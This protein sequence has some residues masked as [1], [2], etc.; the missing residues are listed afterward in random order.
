MGR[1]ARA[2]AVTVLCT[3]LAA[4]SMAGA[5]ADD[6]PSGGSDAR[7]LVFRLRITG[8]VA[9]AV[10]TTCPAPADGDVCTDTIIFGFDTRDREGNVRSD[11]PVLR[12]LTF[13]Y[14]FVED[15][16]APSEPIAEWFG[17]LEGADVEGD[18]RLDQVTAQGVVP[19]QV[20]TVF[21]P[22]SGL[23]CPD[24]VDVSATWTGVGQRQ[25]I[26]EHTV[27]RMPTRRPVRL[28][29][30]WTRGWQRDA[31]AVATL[32]GSPVP[33]VLMFAQLSRVDQGEI[34]VQHPLG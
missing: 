15:P 18:P 28:E 12:I 9:E 25:R 27:V 11:T 32:D 20:C 2:L 6:P 24:S 21:D 5:R 17:R 7:T 26:D 30:T 8:L 13:V 14:R 33:G 19:I 16:E 1:L 23:T 4:P 34:V 29:N 22:A 10:W 31:T 3:L